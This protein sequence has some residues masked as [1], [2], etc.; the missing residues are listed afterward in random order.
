MRH[1]GMEAGDYVLIEGTD[2]GSG[3]SDEIARHAFEPLFTTKP[4]GMGTGLGLA[5]VQALAEQAG[6]AAR[7]ETALGRGTTVFL[8]LPRWSGAD[9]TPIADDIPANEGARKVEDAAT[10]LLVEDNEEVAAG[11]VAVLDVLGWHARHEATGD[12]ALEVLKEGCAFDLVLSDI[13]MPGA[14]D[15]IGLAEWIRKQRPLQPVTLMT[16]YADHLAEARRLGVSVLAK[17]FNADDLKALLTGVPI[18]A[19]D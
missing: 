13:Q 10:I 17:P 2:T 14:V 4:A 15:G 1:Y 9:T 18:C 8:Y 16:G 5:Q 7:L 12:A 11:L 3:M 6:G 19:S